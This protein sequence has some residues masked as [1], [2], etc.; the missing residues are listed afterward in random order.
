MD[1]RQ[2]ASHRVEL[3][4]KFKLYVKL[5]HYGEKARKTH[6]FISIIVFLFSRQ[7][8]P[9]A[10]DSHLHYSIKNLCWEYKI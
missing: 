5:L 7:S 10:T 8:L 1:H 3:E 9:L 2:Y 6:V 4:H